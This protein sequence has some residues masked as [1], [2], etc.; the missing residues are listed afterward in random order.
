MLELKTL[1]MKYLKKY[2]I[3]LEADIQVNDSDEPGVKVAKEEMNDVQQ[4]MSEFTQ[5]KSQID[6]LYSTIKDKAQLEEKIKSLLGDEESERNPF[7]V[8]YLGVSKLKKEIED[9]QD[10]NVKDKMSLDDF[11]EEMNL[12]KDADTK[13]MVSFKV[14]DIKNRISKNSVELLKKIQE[15]QEKE[16]KMKEEM[17]KIKKDI[18]QD[19]KTIEEEQQK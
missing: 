17:E 18:E 12:S 19:S 4:Q 3:F 16:A 15:V 5:K 7:L 1:K 11:S 9:I 13:K 8:N 10:K 6:Q 2:K 14:S